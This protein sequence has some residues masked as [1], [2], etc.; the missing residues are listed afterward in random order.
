M[1]YSPEIG[2]TFRFELKPNPPQYLKQIMR[3][4]ATEFTRLPRELRGKKNKQLYHVI[5]ALFLNKGADTFRDL[6]QR[7]EKDNV[8]VGSGSMLIETD[9]VIKLLTF[10]NKIKKHLVCEPAVSY[11]SLYSCEDHFLMGSVINQFGDIQ[12]SK[13]HDSFFAAIWKYP[14]IVKSQELDGSEKTLLKK[15]FN[16]FQMYTDYDPVFTHELKETTHFTVV[17]QKLG[18]GSSHSFLLEDQNKRKIAAIVNKLEE[19]P[20]IS[21]AFLDVGHVGQPGKSRPFPNIEPKIYKAPEILTPHFPKN[22]MDILSTALFSLY[23]GK[24]V[25]PKGVTHM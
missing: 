6:G 14:T 22:V 8:F 19:D 7:Y 4:S 20:F 11:V 25:V 23:N 9:T 17:N 18:F 10:L 15:S 21:V 12:F 13:K 1:S 3:S 24:L 5:P 16:A 2:F